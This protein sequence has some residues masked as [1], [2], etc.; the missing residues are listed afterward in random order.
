VAIHFTSTFLFKITGFF[1]PTSPFFFLFPLSLSSSSLFFPPLL[2]SSS[3]A[4]PVASLYSRRGKKKKRKDL[5]GK[6]FF[7]FFSL[8]LSEPEKLK[9]YWSLFLFLVAARSS[10]PGGRKSFP[11]Y[12]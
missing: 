2:K 1:L 5:K 4:V 10:S 7:F 8:F 11:F 3:P 9:A 12:L 6:T